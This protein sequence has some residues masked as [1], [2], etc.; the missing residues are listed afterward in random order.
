[1]NGHCDWL[2]CET[3]RA[4]GVIARM[5]RLHVNEQWRR[6]LSRLTFTPANTVFQR[7]QIPIMSQIARK[8]SWRK[9]QGNAVFV[10]SGC[11]SSP[12]DVRGSLHVDTVED[13]IRISMEGPSVDEFDAKEAVQMWLS[14]AKR[15]RRPNYKGWPTQAPYPP[16]RGDLF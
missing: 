13:L 9:K 6:G 5:H 10:M 11:A 16:S 1:M 2:M 12:G 7:R 4:L 14:Q 8:R 15:T 3:R